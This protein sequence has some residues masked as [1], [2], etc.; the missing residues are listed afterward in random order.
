[1]DKGRQTRGHR[2]WIDG[3]LLAS[4]VSEVGSAF[5]GLILLVRSLVFDISEVVVGVRCLW[6]VVS[7]VKY[8]V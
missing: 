4:S 2:V 6:L 3:S 5:R 8:V 7:D 1:M